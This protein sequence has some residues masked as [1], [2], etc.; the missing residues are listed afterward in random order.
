MAEL[1]FTEHCPFSELTLLN[2]NFFLN[3]YQSWTSIPCEFKARDLAL[4]LTFFDGVVNSTEM[5]MAIAELVYGKIYYDDEAYFVDVNS[6]EIGLK[7][8]ILSVNT[9]LILNKTIFNVLELQTTELIEKTLEKELNP[10][11]Q[12]YCFE[13]EIKQNNLSALMQIAQDFF[14]IQVNGPLREWMNGTLKAR[15]LRIESVARHKF[16]CVERLAFSQ[17]NFKRP[18]NVLTDLYIRDVLKDAVEN[19]S[20]GGS[21]Q[22]RIQKIK[23]KINLGMDQFITLADVVTAKF[24]LNLCDEPEIKSPGTIRNHY[25]NGRHFI[26]FSAR[27]AGTYQEFCAQDFITLVQQYFQLNEEKKETIIA[28]NYL[29]KLLG[30]NVRIGNSKDEIKGN[31]KSNLPYAECMSEK[32]IVKICQLLNDS[33]LTASQKKDALFMV[34][35][36]SK[37]P[38]RREDVATLRLKDLVST[39][40]P[41]I[42]FSS[43]TI[44][45]KKSKN[46]NRVVDG[47]ALELGEIFEY[48]EA[49]KMAFDDHR[50]GLFSR[51]DNLESFENGYEILG[52][53]GSAMRATTGAKD[54]SPHNF[55]TGIISNSIRNLLSVEFSQQSTSDS[56]RLALFEAFVLSGHGDFRTTVEHYA[57][58]FEWLR[59]E[60]VDHIT[61]EHLQVSPQFLSSISNQNSETLRKYANDHH[62]LSNYLAKVLTGLTL[63]FEDRVILIKDFLNKEIQYYPFDNKNTSVEDTQLVKICYQALILAGLDV[64]VTADLLNVTTSEQEQLS[65]NF[66]LL[67]LAAR[68]N[69]T[70]DLPIKQILNLGHFQ[71][72]VT[73]LGE[74][75]LDATQI[76]GI[77]Q[78][79][80]SDIG[81]A[82]RLEIKDFNLFP[83]DFFRRIERAGFETIFSY[84]N[85]ANQIEVDQIVQRLLPKHKAQIAL[86][87]FSKYKSTQIRFVFRGDEKNTWPRR[88]R[89]ATTWVTLFLISFFTTKI[90]E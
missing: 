61:S 50:A 79:F 26:Q 48:A 7:R 2:A 20:Y 15:T 49:K 67:S 74:V 69:W 27:D 11:M 59:R 41:H 43:A 85:Y 45:K 14:A 86:R 39:E 40:Y 12:E 78:I 23:D 83:D 89:E 68:E 35:L 3:L 87:N 71:A 72:L 16:D 42:V 13:L 25:Q 38:L 9:I 8:V 47:Y 51:L 22:L 18:R 17:T 36:M 60:W 55:R 46:A 65:K 80:K 54:I 29:F 44:G 1:H 57:C 62:K 81:G 33:A 30:I 52:I 37:V 34:D 64:N 58:F 66:Q 88:C 28:I 24:V 31:K 21:T 10:L 56:L 5:V 53:I 90:S 82:W 32:E 4:S 84:S 63:A 75:H 73:R 76:I 70:T 6:H 77:S 19:A